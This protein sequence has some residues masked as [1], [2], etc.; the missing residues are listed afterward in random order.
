LSGPAWL[1]PSSLWTWGV[2]LVVIGVAARWF[3]WDALLWFPR[4]A[5]DWLAW[6]PAAIVAAIEDS[7]STVG[8]IALGVLLMVVAKIR[9][10]PKGGA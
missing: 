6:A 9:M 7:P 8:L 3:G 4:L 1:K 5:L 10:R 2:C